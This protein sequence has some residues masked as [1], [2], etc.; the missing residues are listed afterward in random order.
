MQTGLWQTT[1]R[2]V[3]LLRAPPRRNSIRKHDDTK[4]KEAARKQLEEQ[5]NLSGT[6]DNWLCANRL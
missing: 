1:Y 3:M 5:Q 6:R 4:R 2:A